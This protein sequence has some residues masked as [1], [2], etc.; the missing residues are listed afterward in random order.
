MTSIEL[1]EILINMT[2]DDKSITEQMI[3]NIIALNDIN[4]IIEEIK[5]LF[6]FEIWD[7]VS[8]VNGAIASLVLKQLPFTF[9][10]WDGLSYYVKVKSTGKIIIFQTDDWRENGWQKITSEAMA[11]ELAEIQILNL[12]TEKAIQLI[13][14]KLRSE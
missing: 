4:L 9:P 12:S 2:K 13:L 3:D 7:E 8:P 1:K 14:S 11:K 10:N 6:A 5:D